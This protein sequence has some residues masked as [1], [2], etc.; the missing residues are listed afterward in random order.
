MIYI[1]PAGLDSRPYDPDMWNFNID[2]LG[3]TNCYTYALDFSGTFTYGMSFGKEIANF[4]LSQPG[5]LTLEGFT[6]Y[7]GMISLT[8]TYTS[9]TYGESR[10][11]IEAL[12]GAMIDA[13]R[14]GHV[15]R[16]ATDD[17]IA[18]NGLGANEWVVYLVATANGPGQQDYHWY[19]QNPDGSWSHKLG[20]TAV[21]NRTLLELH[22]Y[23]Y[24][25][26]ITIPNK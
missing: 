25:N 14:N 19:R 7:S 9:V 4:G 1:D 10:R 17:N 21:T 2:L 15:F 18:G 5:K 22:E 11:G 23:R 8:T 12:A 6:F 16:K 3:R 20:S 13:S 26:G 24:S